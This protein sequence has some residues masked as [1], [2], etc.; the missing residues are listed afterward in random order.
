MRDCLPAF[1]LFFLMVGLFVILLTSVIT[2]EAAPHG[3]SRQKIVKPA[4]LNLVMFWMQECRHCE[5]VRKDILP[6]LQAKYGDRLKMRLIEVV[7]HIDEKALAEIAATHKLTEEETGVP[8]LMIGNQV[9]V[10][11]RPIERELPTLLAKYAVTA[12]P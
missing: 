1:R 8:F 9:F 3:K 11:D 6:P 2:A 10:G 12:I 5:R 4:P 7:D